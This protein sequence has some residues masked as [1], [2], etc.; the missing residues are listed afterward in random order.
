MTTYNTLIK[1]H[2]KNK[3]DIVGINSQLAEKTQTLNVK[4]TMTKM[5]NVAHRGAESVAPQNTIPSTEYA[6]MMGYYG[7]ECDVQITS[8]K[9]WVLFHDDTLDFLTTGTGTVASKTLAEIKAL[10]ID[11]GVY[12]SSRYIGTKIPTFREYL[13][14]CAKYGMIPFV[15]LKKYTYDDL[16]SLFN[17]LEEYNLI[18]KA[19]ILCTPTTL[20]YCRDNINST[21]NAL[22]FING[23]TEEINNVA[24][25]LPY[26]IVGIPHTIATKEMVQEI[27][28]ANLQC[29]VW[30]N[31]V[32]FELLEDNFKKWGV[33]YTIGGII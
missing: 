10:S 33:S 16:P 7:V 12:I 30:T 26:S 13:S 25:N 29:A 6:G 2:N 20:K 28:N 17:I 21:F 32:G 4:S 14:T 31:G 3:D 24:L 27:T 18:N 23:T 8:D 15:E 1:E 11:Y 22:S 19:V 9:E 5:L